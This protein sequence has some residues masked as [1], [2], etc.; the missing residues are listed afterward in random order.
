MTST[1]LIPFTPSDRAF[2]VDF[3]QNTVFKALN[4]L[5]VD[6]SPAWGRMTSLQMI[7]H[8]IW[9]FQVSTNQISI[10]CS[11]PEERRNQ[12]RPFI[13]N[14]QQNPRNFQLPSHQEGLP[15]TQ[16]SSLDLAISALKIEIMHFLERY[17]HD[18]LSLS[19]HPVL[20]SITSDDWSRLHF[21]HCFHHLMQFSLLAEQ[22]LPA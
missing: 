9:T 18:P 17:Q 11:V 1:L 4:S 8:L 14:D 19:T 2:R 3:L 13:F 21:K 16:F 6:Q 15:S 12:V 5:R 22:P 10:T 20:G 7:E